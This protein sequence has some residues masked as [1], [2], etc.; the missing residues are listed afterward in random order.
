MFGVFNDD[1][2]V[3]PRYHMVQLIILVVI[4]IFVFW[5]MISSTV[6]AANGFEGM[7]SNL[8]NY[9]ITSF[10][11]RFASGRTDTGAPYANVDGFLGHPEGPNFWNIGDIK[12]TK[13]ALA[14]QQAAYEGQT[15]WQE[16]AEDW[17]ESQTDWQESAE[18]WNKF[19]QN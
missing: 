7:E 8:K 5:S 12:E 10:D 9:N 4:I 13:K 17:K 1:W 19:R 18:D 14:A 11:T 2:S 3:G 15:D 16:S 6:A